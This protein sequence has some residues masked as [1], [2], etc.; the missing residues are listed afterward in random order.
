MAFVKSPITFGDYTFPSGF[1]VESV[2]QGSQIDQ[3]KAPLR[4]GSLAAPGNMLPK[5]VRIRGTVGGTGAVDSSGNFFVHKADALAELSLLRKYIEGDYTRNDPVLFDRMLTIGASDLRQTRAQKRT[6]TWSPIPG[7]NGTAWDVQ[8]EFLCPDP[9]WLQPTISD[10]GAL[11]PPVGSSSS[12]FDLVVGHTAPTWPTILI[13]VDNGSA[14]TVRVA[15]LQLDGTGAEYIEV[16]SPTP[17]AQSGVTQ[18]TINTD[19]NRRG[20][21]GVINGPY[22]LSAAFDYVPASNHWQ[23]A[24]T[25]KNTIVSDPSLFGEI[26]PVLLP[27]T[28]RVTWSGYTN[29]PLRI[30]WQ[31]A[32]FF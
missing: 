17:P 7:T 5:I 20:G 28:Q 23:Q 24:M 22:L 27:G 31:E 2:E 12:T 29:V 21:R 3:V 8:C 30:Q 32:D 19:P 14:W 1:R 16:A 10:T 6:F 25:T 9:R 26:F 13:G 15:Y 18:H 4:I 11:L